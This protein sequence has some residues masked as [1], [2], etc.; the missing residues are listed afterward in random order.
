MQ[1]N[2]M[3]RGRLTVSIAASALLAGLAMTTPA[4]ATVTITSSVC[5]SCENV[6]LVPTDDGAP[7]SMVAYGDV[8]SGAVDVTFTGIENIVTGQGN[9][10]PWVTGADGSITYL[11]V[12]VQPGYAFTLA[13]FNLNDLPGNGD[14]FVRVSAFDGAT[15]KASTVFGES[16]NTKFKIAATGGD[17]LTHFQIQL[18]TDIG[19]LTPVALNGATV[20][21]GV[22]QV[23]IDDVG[24]VAVPE[25]ATWAM[26]IMGFGGVGSLLRRRRTAPA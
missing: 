6:H 18:V 17:V 2:R 3:T 5:A 22:G 7:G 9:G 15:L 26:M 13:G 11:D 24:A 19:G 16:N 4:A 1:I 25:P 23:R 12:A 8:Q 20:L 10:L 14:W 21:D